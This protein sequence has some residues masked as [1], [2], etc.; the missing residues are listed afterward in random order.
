MAL[1]ELLAQEGV[2][3]GDRGR[4]QGGQEAS[5]VAALDDFIFPSVP[6]LGTV[7]ASPKMRGATAS[8]VGEYRAATAMPTP[9]PTKTP[10]SLI[11]ILTL[12]TNR[13]V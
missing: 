2:A 5:H 9:E 4:L 8:L 1:R 7:Y 11:H 13:E 12:P 3:G 10:L 6:E